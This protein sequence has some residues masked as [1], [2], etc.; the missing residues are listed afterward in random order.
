MNKM[1]HKIKDKAP[2]EHRRKK[3]EGSVLIV[4]LMMLV[5]LTVIGISASRT[6]EIEV[7]IAGNERRYK[8]N[9]YN[10]EAGAMQG[11]Q[12]LENTDLE[13]SPPSW[14]MNEDFENGAGSELPAH[15]DISGNETVD[16]HI[17]KEGNWIND[18]SMESTMLT[19]ARILGLSLGV[20]TSGSIDMTQSKLW[21]YEVYGQSDQNNGQNII[22][23]GY[24]KPF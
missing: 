23:L 19:N 9:L 21:N 22:G 13:G 20:E 14:L 11:V 12:I 5:L 7:M 18:Y 2:T 6:S 3:E 24:R 17:K 1:M 15:A 16:D 10:S 8:Q 4:A